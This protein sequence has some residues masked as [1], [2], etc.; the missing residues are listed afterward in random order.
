MT[1]D[2]K[3]YRIFKKVKTLCYK[4]SKLG[5]EADELNV[6]L[7]VICRNNTNIRCNKENEQVSCKL[8]ELKKILRD[9]VKYMSDEKHEYPQNVV[10]WYDICDTIENLKESIKES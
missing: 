1:E 5:V 3:V 9:K 8:E 2:R 10:G 4:L 6:P 7:E